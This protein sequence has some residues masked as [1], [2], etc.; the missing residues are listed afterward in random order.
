MMALPSLITE[1]GVLYVY[2]CVFT[3]ILNG[4]IHKRY[5][6]AQ[7]HIHT[8]KHAHITPNWRTKRINVG[9]IFVGQ[10]GGLI[11]IFITP[12]TLFRY[13]CV[14]MYVCVS[15]YIYQTQVKANVQSFPFAVYRVLLE[16]AKITNT[17]T[18][19]KIC[20]HAGVCVYTGV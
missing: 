10:I 11:L 14:C 16:Y 13:E 20:V 9:G 2:A 7:A 3:L 17:S 6:R 8:H 4:F 18:M 5:A 1:T 15:V 12:R 19:A